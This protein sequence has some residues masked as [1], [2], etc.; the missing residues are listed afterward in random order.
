MAKKYY[1]VKK[2]RKPGIYESWDQCQK[3]IKGFSQASF[4]GF[5]TYEDA[6]KFMGDA[7]SDNTLKSENKDTLENSSPLEKCNE[8]L[9]IAYVDGSYRDDTKEF[10][11]GAV[12]FHDKKEIHLNAKFNDPSLVL[13]RN[14]AGEIHGSMAAMDY[15]LKK[16]C[17]FLEIFHD[18]EGIAKWC[19]GQW[20]TKKEGTIRYKAFYD[21]VKDKLDIRFVKV[22]G[23]SNDRYNDLADK[24]A[25]SALGI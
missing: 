14:V 19:T 9:A 21:K 11:Y 1:A 12:I 24:L 5:L 8:Q 25:K 16:G 10:S 22:K 15:A 20:Q 7:L 3:Q 6:L 23:H 18:Y 13:M 4:K 2:G 17:K